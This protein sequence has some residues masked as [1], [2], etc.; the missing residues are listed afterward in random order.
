MARGTQFLSLVTDL[1][2]ELR[3]SSSVAVG[4]DDLDSLK[5]VLNRVYQTL[6]MQYDWPHLKITFKAV[7]LVAGQRYYDFPTGAWGGA[8]VKLIYERVL[9]VAITHSG[10]VSDLDR[11]IDFEQY[12][13]FSSDD[14]ERSEP[15]LRW[16]VTWTGTS[17]QIEVW[18]IPN[19][20][21]QK[22]HFKGVHN[23]PPLVADADNCLLDDHLVVLFCAAELL[24]A[25]GAKDASL[26]LNAAQG[27]LKMLQ[28]RAQGGVRGYQMGLGR[29]G[30]TTANRATVRIS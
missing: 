23:T 3:R 28:A 1:R 24:A 11:G 17:D 19:T 18:P 12:A 25:Q 10:A 27:H 8:A 15:T 6:V 2:A 21:T 14:D 20:N 7:S 4:V 16:D 9:R 30:T 29:Q 26:K 22:L 13:S 5:Q